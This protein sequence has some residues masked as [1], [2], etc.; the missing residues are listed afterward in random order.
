MC[1]AQ[2]VYKGYLT[3]QDLTSARPV[4]LKHRFP[5][6][7]RHPALSAQLTRARITSEARS[8]AR[9]TRGGVQVPQ[10]VLVDVDSGIIGIEWI[11]GKTV[12]FVLGADE[13]L[14]DD[15]DG[16]G[17]DAT[18]GSGSAAEYGISQGRFIALNVVCRSSSVI[19]HLF[20]HSLTRFRASTVDTLMQLIGR[21]LGRMHRVDII[22]GDLTTSNMIVRRTT[23]TTTSTGGVS[24]EIVSDRPSPGKSL[25]WFG[26]LGRSSLTLGSRFNRPWLR[27][28]LWT[29]MC[30]SG[31]LHRHTHRRGRCL[32]WYW[33]HTG[34]SLG[35]RR[36][37]VSGGDWE[38]VLTPMSIIRGTDIELIVR[39]RGRKRSM[40]G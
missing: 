7:Y 35:P 24:A 40:L 13:E 21:E 2:K 26:S 15:A 28:K 8:L 12:R 11:D 10:V 38:K 16:G 14:M 4:L 33:T 19:H 34:G 23:A 36:G 9:C 37:R 3:D 32:Q 25:T 30:S 39:L 17:K 6:R 1:R 5:K 18:S 31:H 27:I 29:C 22:H 20:I